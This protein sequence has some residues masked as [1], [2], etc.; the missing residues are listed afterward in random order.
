MAT[1]FTGADVTFFTCDLCGARLEWTEELAG[2]AVRCGCGALTRCPANRPAVPPREATGGSLQ[3]AGTIPQAHVR[4]TGLK[5]DYRSSATKAAA[6]PQTLKDL[7][8]PLWLLGGGI[9]IEIASAL[10]IHRSSLRDACMRIA[11]QLVVGTVMMLA[12][13]LI[14]ARL[15]GINLGSFWNAAF[16]L[17]AISVAPAAAVALAEPVLMIIP[18]GWLLGW[19]AEFVLFFALLG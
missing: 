1:N 15:R 9:V 19:I 18:F 5:L 2:Q 10:L 12:A 16:K 7:Y 8:M 17:S 14:A 13:I 4:P 11:I 3:D 6:D